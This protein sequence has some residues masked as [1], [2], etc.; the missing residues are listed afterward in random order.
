M[1][2]KKK[3]EEE[4][5]AETTEVAV[6]KPKEFTG[7]DLLP[8]E[9]TGVQEVP[10]I[11]LVGDEH[12]DDA[13]MVLP[14]LVL[15]HGT[16]KAVTDG[17][18][19][20]EPGRFMHTG[21]EQV[22]PEGPMRIMIAH[23]HKGN[24]LFPKE[25]ERYKDIE[26]CI[27]ADGI[28]GSTYGLC[29]ECGKCYWPENGG[30]PL[31]DAKSPLGGEVHHFVCMTSIGPAMLRMTKSAYKAGSKFLT[32]KRTSGKNFWAHPVVVRVLQEPKTLPTGK[33]TMYHT[34]Q[35]AWQTTERVPAGLQRAAYELYKSVKAKHETGNLKSQ[36]DDTE[37][38]GEFD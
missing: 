13:D 8:Y 21:T 19:D 10:D 16:S 35:M 36:D 29:S 1:A 30:Q 32:A 38:A 26:T 37:A 22:L 4:K 3:A 24:A 9:Q 18:E 15:L 25:D 23:Y 11:P 27:S 5:T 34:M 12:I 2:A 28:E 6:W 33:V 17:I 14:A 20:A 7:N 31:G